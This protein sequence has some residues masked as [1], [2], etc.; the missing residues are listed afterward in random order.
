MRFH[1]KGRLANAARRENRAIREFKEHKANLAH[2]DRKVCR[3]RLVPRDPKATKELKVNLVRKDCKVRRERPARRDPKAT[4]E[5]KAN[6]AHRDRKDCVENGENRVRRSKSM[7]PDRGKTYLNM[8]MRLP[9]SVFSILI[10][11]VF[12]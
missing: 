4:K 8:M 7:H 5:N 1:F 6:P 12:T 10:R 3:E 2:R 9:I 11:D